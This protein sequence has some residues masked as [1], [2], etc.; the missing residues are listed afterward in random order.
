MWPAATNA[1]QRLRSM[2]MGCGQGR[3]RGR[4]RAAIPAKPENGR[5]IAVIG[6][7]DHPNTREIESRNRCIGALAGIAGLRAAAP[8][9]PGDAGKKRLRLDHQAAGVAVKSSRGA[10]FPDVG[11]SCWSTCATASDERGVVQSMPGAACE[12]PLRRPG[13]CPG[14]VRGVGRQGATMSTPDIG[15]ITSDIDAPSRGGGANVAARLVVDPRRPGRKLPSHRF[16][17]R[18]RGRRRGQGERVWARRRGRCARLARSRLPDV[19]HCVQPRGGRAQKNSRRRGDLRAH[20]DGRRGGARS[21]R[22]PP[23][24]ESVRSGRHR[25]MDGECTGARCTGTRGTPH[26]DRHP[27]ARSRREGT[28]YLAWRRYPAVP[29]ST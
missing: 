12:G 6:R 13:M 10:G 28:R 29:V 25:P 15:A 11:G 8:A 5:R 22:A 14:A 23:D 19:L 7:P 21:A 27:P 1:R 3:Y 2:L 20:A 4:S 9:R 18:C 16:V 26:R 24:S 17:D